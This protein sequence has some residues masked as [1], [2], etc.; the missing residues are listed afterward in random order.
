VEPVHADTV[1]LYLKFKTNKKKLKETKLRCMSIPRSLFMV[2]DTVALRDIQL[3][4]C[5]TNSIYLQQFGFT[6]SKKQKEQSEAGTGTE[7]I[8]Q[9]HAVSFYLAHWVGVSSVIGQNKLTCDW[10]DWPMAWGPK[11]GYY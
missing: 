10:L 9:A 5:N 3:Q 11:K 2:W 6:L 8:L 7:L 1:E 4:Y